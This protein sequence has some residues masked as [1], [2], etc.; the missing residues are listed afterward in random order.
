[1]PVFSPLEIIRITIKL[2]LIATVIAILFNFSSEFKDI[3]TN[4]LGKIGLS[5][6]SVDGL[7]L[8]W[9]AGAIGLTL[10]LNTLMGNVVTAGHVLVGAVIAIFI[11]KYS[12]QIYAFLTKA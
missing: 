6:N 10:F 1:M 11:F 2:A 12:V 8:G 3:A 7:D 4:L 9:F 5:M